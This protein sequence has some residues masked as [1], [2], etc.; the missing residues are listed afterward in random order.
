MCH[1]GDK[2]IP[3]PWGN[4]GKDVIR[5]NGEKRGRGHKRDGPVGVDTLISV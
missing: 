4:L 3:C 1:A 2:A 5:R